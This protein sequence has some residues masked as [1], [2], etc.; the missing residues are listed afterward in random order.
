MSQQSHYST[1][2]LVPGA[3]LVE[4]KTA[5]RKLMLQHHPD[6]CFNLSPHVQAAGEL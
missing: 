6:K 5:Y 1:L 3:S 2:G 4:I